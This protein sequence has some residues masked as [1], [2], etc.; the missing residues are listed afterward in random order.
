MRLN[1]EHMSSH[2]N[3]YQDKTLITLEPRTLIAKPDLFQYL[4]YR[5]FLGDYVEWKLKLNPSFSRRAF[6]LK[7]FGSTGILY[8][9][10]GGDRDLGTQAPGALRRG[11]GAVR[12]G[13]RVFRPAGPA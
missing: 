3:D 5:I 4:D 1:L 13:K 12:E 2:G 11:P 8:S 7:Y 10:I 9:V 6:S